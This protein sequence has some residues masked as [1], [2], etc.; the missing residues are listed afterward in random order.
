MALGGLLILVSISLAI[1]LLGIAE[2]AD[3]RSLLLVGMLSL[4]GL[5]SVLS[6]GFLFARRFSV[7]SG[8]GLSAVGIIMAVVGV[9]VA[10]VAFGW[11]CIHHHWAYGAYDHETYAYGCWLSTMLLLGGTF[12]IGHKKVVAGVITQIRLNKKAKLGA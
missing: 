10:V 6:G 2:Q 3:D 12:L 7:R 5:F 1:V 9:A 11:S 4:A 8:W